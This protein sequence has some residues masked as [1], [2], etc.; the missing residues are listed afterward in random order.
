MVILY[1]AN[2]RPGIRLKMHSRST[3]STILYTSQDPCIHQRASE[4]LATG[5]K[6]VAI[7]YLFTWTMRHE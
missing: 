4:K 5:T 3:G 2:S 1:V 7:D 6:T